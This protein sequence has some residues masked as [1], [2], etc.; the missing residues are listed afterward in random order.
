MN[1]DDKPQPHIIMQPAPLDTVFLF[2]K[3]TI[4]RTILIKILRW[5]NIAVSALDQAFR[6]IKNRSRGTFLNIESRK[7]FLDFDVD[8][9]V[10]TT[11]WHVPAMS[12]CLHGLQLL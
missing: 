4:C 7:V 9:A 12:C 8:L 6:M 3:E 10:P 1:W 2:H 5:F 11:Y